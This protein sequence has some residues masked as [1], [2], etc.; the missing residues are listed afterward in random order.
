MYYDP[1]LFPYLQ[2]LSENY[3]TILR[4][5]C[6][7]ADSRLKPMID[8]HITTTG[9]LGFPLMSS[10]YRFEDNWRLC[11]E[12]VALIKDIPGLYAAGF[13]VLEPHTELPAHKNFPMDIYRMHMG[14]IVPENCAFIVAGETRA[15]VEKKWLIFCPE[16]EHA[17][18]NRADT[19]RVIFL[20]DVWRNPER[21][22][23]RDRFL[24]WLGGIKI[25]LSFTAPGKKF[26]HFVSTNRSARKVID[27][28]TGRK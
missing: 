14:L 9:W 18:Y 13:Y 12:T 8:A 28:L 7:V 15:W 20:L 22:P 27:W 25:R 4:E 3:A 5:F 1:S 24:T 2:R 19:R 10:A 26:L 17:G 16:V 11:P 23:L 21:R 6:E